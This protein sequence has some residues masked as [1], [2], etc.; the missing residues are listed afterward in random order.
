MDTHFWETVSFLIFI[1]LVYKPVA[2]QVSLYLKDYSRNVKD[3]IEE[4]TKLRLESEK[5]LAFYEEE[6]SLLAT[7]LKTM[8]RQTEE[9]VSMLLYKSSIK[10]EEQ[11]KIR[12]DMHNEKIVIYQKEA[13]SKLKLKAIADAV[14]VTKHYFTANCHKALSNDDVNDALKVIP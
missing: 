1:I 4:A 3:K 12:K 10:L 6:A 8:L 11:I 14:F 13:I 5:Y 2:K 9:N 7:R